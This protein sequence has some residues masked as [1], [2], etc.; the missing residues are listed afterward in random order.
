MP[1]EAR[2]RAFGRADA[3]L[4][5]TASPFALGVASSF[6]GRAWRMRACDEEIARELELTGLSA[7]LSQV[8]ASRDVTKESAENFLEP[9]LK[10]LLPDPYLFANMERA[11]LRFAEARE[12]GRDHSRFSAITMSMAPARRR[13]C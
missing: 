6:A 12:A 9:R 13:C 3:A 11:A 8:L 4:Q 10:N 2:A 7:G 1:V 5:G